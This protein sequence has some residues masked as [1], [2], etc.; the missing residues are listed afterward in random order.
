LAPAPS[1]TLGAVLDLAKQA[2]NT[3]PMRTSGGLALRAPGEGLI[4]L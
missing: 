4:R 3:H 1:C 2:D